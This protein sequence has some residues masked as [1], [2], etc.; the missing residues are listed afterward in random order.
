MK[1]LKGTTIILVAILL[2][3]GAATFINSF[4]SCIVP[5]GLWNFA[6]V[7]VLAFMGLIYLLDESRMVKEQTLAFC[8]KATIV[9]FAVA[10][11]SGDIF[12]LLV[13][14][15]SPHCI[16]PV[17]LIAYLIAFAGGTMISLYECYNIIKAIIE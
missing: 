16:H 3:I 8:V 2:G 17:M 7:F 4:N 9:G 6:F 12:L 14:S 1:Y 15:A 5:F 10:F 11:F 13:F